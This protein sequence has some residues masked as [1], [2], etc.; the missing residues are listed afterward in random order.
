MVRVSSAVTSK[1]RKKKVLKLAK[2][3]FGHRKSRFRQAVK[4]VHKGLVYQF[5]DRKVRKRQFRS[6]WI[7]RINAACKEEG[8]GY[9]RFINGLKK[10]NVEMDRKVLADL[11]VSQPQAFRKLV[12]LAKA[13]LAA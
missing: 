8:I 1:Q 2:G 13:K 4:S 11:A 6:L 12:E 3:Q 10:A 9:N 7:I 5:R